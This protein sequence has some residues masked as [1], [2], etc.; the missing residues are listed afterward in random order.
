MLE[1]R[2]AGHR[3]AR[4]RPLWVPLVAAAL[5][6]MACGSSG[7]SHGDGG[8][9]GGFEVGSDAGP[10]AGMPQKLMILHTNDIHS[11]LMGFAPELDYTPATPNDDAT[12]GGM[13]RLASAIGAA[14]AA[15][16]ADGTPV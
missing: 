1:A 7:G 9:D 8:R 6:T 16:A 5:L 4:F 11:H 12:I 3:D 13:A 10:E 14:K 15:A 2:C